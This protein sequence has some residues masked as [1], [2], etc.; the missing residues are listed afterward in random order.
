MF[1]PSSY[2][3]PSSTGARAAQLVPH[4]HFHIIPRPNTDAVPTGTK[5]S[6]VMFGRG[7]RD[8]LDDEEGEQVAKAMREEL[9]REVVRIKES[10]GIDLDIDSE[11]EQKGRGHER[12]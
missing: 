8:D 3:P 10:E 1:S 5:T 6:W 9:A 11:P 4:V 12:L 7:Q 2:S